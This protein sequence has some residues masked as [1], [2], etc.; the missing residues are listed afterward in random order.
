VLW[1]IRIEAEL[2]M[3][4]ANRGLLGSFARLHLAAWKGELAAV[5]SALRALDQEHLTVERV[6]LN[7]LA[8]TVYATGSECHWWNQECGD[9]GNARRPLNGW[10]QVNRLKAGESSWG[11]VRL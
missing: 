5:R 11:E 6:H 2:L 8:A 7:A 10:I 9:C 4:F 1:I 3:E